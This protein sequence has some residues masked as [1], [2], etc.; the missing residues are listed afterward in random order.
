LVGGRGIVGDPQ[1]GVGAVTYGLD[2][3]ERD[4]SEQEALLADAGIEF[5]VTR[6]PRVG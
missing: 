2:V 5:V 4:L 6:V 3:D 1:N